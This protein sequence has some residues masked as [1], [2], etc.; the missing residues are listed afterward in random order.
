MKAVKILVLVAFLASAALIAG[1]QE[2]EHRSSKC[3]KAYEEKSDI[4]EYTGNTPLEC[5]K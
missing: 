5:T 4:Y 1:C 2:S 3:Q